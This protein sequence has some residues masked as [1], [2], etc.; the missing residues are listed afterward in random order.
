MIIIFLPCKFKKYNENQR[1]KEE[2]F[3]EN[4]DYVR[5]QEALKI[6]KK[7]EL[8]KEKKQ[9]FAAAR[10]TAT[11]ENSNV[12]VEEISEQVPEGNVVNNVMETDDPWLARKQTNAVSAV[13]AT[14]TKSNS[15]ETVIDSSVKVALAASG[16]ATKAAVEAAVDVAIPLS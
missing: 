14:G 3:R 9:A 1:D 4:I 13:V 7:E 12:S 6:E 2:H 5:E 11:L 8:I 10:D 16:A 15:L